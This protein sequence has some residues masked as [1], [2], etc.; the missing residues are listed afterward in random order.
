M[1]RH[2]EVT[3]RGVCVSVHSL[4]VRSRSRP[5]DGQW[6][7]A[8]HVEIA[9]RGEASVQ[10]ISRHWVITDGDGHV[11]E[12]RGP[13]VVGEQ[14]RLQPGERFEYTSACPLPT[15]FGTMHGSYQMVTEDGEQF[16]AAIE[17]FSLSLPN[18]LN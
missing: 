12:V 8:Y 9:N 1:A 14:P 3:T 6:F 10:L 5:E 11:E 18:L 17:A 13:G 2:S 7:F 16:D 15:P 4:Y